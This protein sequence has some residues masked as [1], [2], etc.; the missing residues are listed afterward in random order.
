V[1]TAVA[2]WPAKPSA[3]DLLARRLADGWRPTPTRLQSGPAVLG[4][5]AC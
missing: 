3:D 4:H 2:V 1:L 5:A